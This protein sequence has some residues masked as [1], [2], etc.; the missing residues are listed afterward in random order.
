MTSASVQSTAKTIPGTRYVLG[1]INLSGLAT[2]PQ[3]TYATPSGQASAPLTAENSTAG[4][5]WDGSEFKHVTF[6]A[7]GDGINVNSSSDFFL[8]KLVPVTP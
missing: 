7:W 3:V 4:I 6:T 1:I 5:T 8:W 2:V